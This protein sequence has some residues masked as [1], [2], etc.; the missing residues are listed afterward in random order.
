MKQQWYGPRTALQQILKGMCIV[1]HKL[2]IMQQENLTQQ[3]D[4]VFLKL[5]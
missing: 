4:Q 2:H 5:Q 1:F 3:S